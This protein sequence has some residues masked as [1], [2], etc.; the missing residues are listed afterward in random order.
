MA[1]AQNLAVG[2]TN[3]FPPD[4]YDDESGHLVG[5][6]VELA[7]AL[8][9]Q[10]GEKP[11]IIRDSWDNI[12][13]SLRRHLNISIAGGMEISDER[14]GLFDFSVPVYRRRG[15]LVVAASN[16][17]VNG[18]G[19]LDGKKITGDSG[20]WIQKRLE[21]AQAE[22]GLRLIVTRTKE[23][24]MGMLASGRV[25]A[26]LMPEAVAIYLARKLG[27]AIRCIDIGDSG[28][29]VAFGFAKGNTD[30]VARVNAGLSAMAAK[31]ELAAILARWLK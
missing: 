17:A 26:C 21:K 31:G 4:Q 10:I 14:L 19:D 22:H 5:L 7:E 28:S 24:A 6:D 3:G 25:D 13:G 20:T 9:R 11:L 1:P 18:I 12:V 23:E 27:L 30:L 8:F 16:K 29:Q 2:L 15:V